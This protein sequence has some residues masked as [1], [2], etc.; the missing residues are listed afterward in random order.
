[1][2]KKLALTQVIAI[3]VCNREHCIMKA[4]KGLRTG[5]LN[6]IWVMRARMLDIRLR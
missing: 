5:F 3:I 4:K 1:M 6:L 2:E